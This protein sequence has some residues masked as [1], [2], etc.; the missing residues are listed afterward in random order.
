MGLLRKELHEIN[1]CESHLLQWLLSFILHPQTESQSCR[2]WKSTKSHLSDLYSYI[3]LSY[4]L[5]A[6]LFEMKPPGICVTM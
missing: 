3:S 1:I 5:A 4:L 2:F 6:N